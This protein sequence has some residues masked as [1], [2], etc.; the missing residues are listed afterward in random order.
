MRERPRTASIRIEG[1][2]WNKKSARTY[3]TEWTAIKPEVE[4]MRWQRLELCNLE[5]FINTF[6]IG[7]NLC[8]QARQGDQD[9]MEKDSEALRI[10]LLF[11]GPF[12]TV[13]ERPRT[14]SITGNLERCGSDRELLPLQVI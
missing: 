8:L 7:Y 13:R 12:R 4:R 3:G 1:F 5:K 9:F 14:A 6:E 2:I 10:L 11:V